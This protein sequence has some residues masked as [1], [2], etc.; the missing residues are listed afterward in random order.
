MA[1]DYT[2][3]NARTKIDSY[4]LP[5]TD[6]VLA[7]M[8]G[9][10]YYSSVDCCSGFFQIRMEK[11]SR[12]YTCIT[13]HLGTYE[14]SVMP[15][16]LASAPSHFSRVIAIM[17]SGMLWKCAAAFIDDI[18]IYS[19]TFEEHIRDLNLLFARCRKWSISLKPK[20]AQ[21]FRDSIEYVGFKVS[22]EGVEPLLHRVEAIQNIAPPRTLKQLRSF[23]QTVSFY[24]RFIPA[25]A[26]LSRPLTD[27]TK[28]ENWPFK[29]W[30]F[31]SPEQRAFQNLKDKLT[32]YPVLRH[33]DFTLPYVL[34][35]DACKDGYGAALQQDFPLPDGTTDRY[36]R[37]HERH[38]VYYISRKTRGAEQNYSA[39]KL[40][41]SAVLWALDKLKH[42]VQG[43]ATTVLT[44]HG[45]LTWLFSPKA[46][47]D[48][49]LARYALR[50]Q[51]WS[52]WL[53][54]KHKPGVIHG[55]ADGLSRLAVN[56]ENDHTEIAD[57][58]MPEG[59]Y[60]SA[61]ADSPLTDYAPGVQSLLRVQEGDEAL[62]DTWAKATKSM[63]SSSKFM[64]A[65][66]A[67]QE[68]DE[69]CCLIRKALE[70]ELPDELGEEGTTRALQLAKDKVINEDG[71]VCKTI[72]ASHFSGTGPTVRRQAWV[73]PPLHGLRMKI[74]ESFH[75]HPL[76]SHIGA[77]RMLALAIPRFYWKGMH[78]A[79]LRYCKTC[80]KCQRYKCYRRV[81]AGKLHPKNILHPMHTL[82]V[83]LQGKFPLSFG[84]QYVMVVIDCFTRWLILVPIPDKKA[85]TVAD[86]LFEHVIIAHSCFKRLLS[87][88]GGEFINRVMKRLCERLNIERIHTAPYKPST[89]AQVE[90]V[91]SFVKKALAMLANEHPS[92][93]S[94]YLSAVCFAYRTTNVS[95]TKVTPF[96]AMYGRDA[97][98]PLDVVT[99][100][101]D[102]LKVDEEQYYLPHFKR[103]KAAW[104]AIRCNQQVANEYE[105][106]R[107]TRYDVSYEV[108]DQVLL[109]R[110][111]RIKGSRRLLSDFIGPLLIGKKLGD[112]HYEV[113]NP[114]SQETVV[115]TTMNLAP[116]YARDEDELE[117]PP[118]RQLGEWELK[119]PFILDPKKLTDPARAKEAPRR[120]ELVNQ[121]ERPSDSDSD[122]DEVSRSNSDD[123][124]GGAPDDPRWED[125]NVAWEELSKEEQVE[126]VSKCVE[127]VNATNLRV[128]IAK[129]TLANLPPTL[130]LGVFTLVE[131]REKSFLGSYRGEKIGLKEKR[132][133]YPNENAHYVLQLSPRKFIDATDPRFAGF[134]RWIN[135]SGD[136]A[137]NCEF[138]AV[139]GQVY[140]RALTHLVKGTEL[141]VSYGP[142]FDWNEGELR[143]A[144]EAARAS[145]ALDV[146]IEEE[147]PA[148]N[149]FSWNLVD[150]PED[151][152]L[153]YHTPDSA[154]WKLG[155][156][157]GVDEPAKLVEAHRYG[158]YGRLKNAQVNKC[159]FAP[160]YV[161]PR[162]GKTVFTFK[163]VARY[164]P[165]YD[166][167][168]SEDIAHK[169]FFLSNQK[170]IPPH[171]AKF[172]AH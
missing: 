99:S 153:I 20:K 21:L 45:P 8:G 91:N 98:L 155:M 170:R 160:A 77:K 157:S 125:L 2:Q 90:R 144:P 114:A 116:Y 131:V 113:F 134:A 70:D 136:T 86:A 1:C 109:Y 111:S 119:A 60:I 41:A 127:V 26:V 92:L 95:T 29:P 76:A 115:A 27:L 102:V 93:W 110:P 32:S 97:V 87:D 154:N 24:R 14:W 63:A 50:L 94:N 44:D 171:V 100:S 72:L 150:L 146:P 34:A 101:P 5:N 166:L 37:T 164:E 52:P 82:C 165:I 30:L 162:D 81:H 145:V 89:N 61:V 80:P 158:S 122:T 108:D 18:V 104:D 35:V 56:M 75:D 12:K 57:I 149:D 152:F 123:E 43:A 9:K 140:I 64:A 54:I 51:S 133:R 118:P 103:L 142:S 23:I 15:F 88:Q 120:V 172:L 28:Q 138:V 124:P 148:Q 121:V 161:D 47:A 48:S 130:D 66:K 78:E 19:S 73:I 31:D 137:P 65:V 13:T 85:T 7:S 147:E 159:S 38:P 107:S 6:D 139:S 143:S 151:S 67:A 96:E 42:F 71:I 59:Y 135:D 74:M 167:M 168:T 69:E 10:R 3:L 84:N 22:R 25:F 4:P 36:G 53:T 112:H 11:P 169:G 33:P 156:L 141:F 117:R 128:S 39:S 55:D 46:M 126:L 105:V 16:G 58:L 62:E 129:S 83:D 17:L 79:V 163:P 132:R 40:E 49:A 68:Q 106:D